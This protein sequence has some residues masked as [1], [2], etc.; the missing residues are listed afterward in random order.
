MLDTIISVTFPELRVP[1]SKW[2]EAKF[3]VIQWQYR[4]TD[5]DKMDGC[6]PVLML[7]RFNRTKL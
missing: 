6:A 2:I 1:F 5:S 7:Q 3:D 4:L